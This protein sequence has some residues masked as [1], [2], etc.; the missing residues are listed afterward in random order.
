[1]FKQ[2]AHFS[3]ILIL[4]LAML[5]SVLPSR[6]LAKPG[7]VVL[8]FPS[9][10]PSPQDL[11]WDGKYLWIVDDSTDKIYKLDPSDGKVLLS[12]PSIGSE[13]KGLTWDGKYLWNSDNF[14]HKTYKL[15]SAKG[16][17]VS[18]ID[19]PVMKVKRGISPLGGLA[20]DGNYLWSGWVA[21]WSSRMNQVNPKDGSIK[22]FYFS[23]GFPRALASDGKF[24]W[25]ATDNA[26]I[27]LGIIYQYNLSD[28]LY[29][30]HFDTPGFYPTGIAFDGQH[31]WCVDKE[32]KRIY[33]LAAK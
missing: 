2:K 25:S 18:I 3:I 28:G 8:S 11:A 14:S 5:C 32:T 6:G 20:W 12:F 17:M 7:D 15:D 27:R 13:P 9:P 21:G 26:G 22:K 29:V 23:K 4:T 16:T 31:L 33:K 30:S 19:A 1:M 10:G 24:L